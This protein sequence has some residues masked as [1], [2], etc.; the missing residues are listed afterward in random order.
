MSDAD[1]ISSVIRERQLA[2]RRELDRRNIALKALQYDS[3]IPYQ[4]ILSYF[5]G[6]KDRQPAIMPLSAFFRLIPVL[7]R[8]LVDL[9]LPHGHMIIPVPEGVDHD[10]LAAKAGEFAL[11][12]AHARHPNSEAGIDIG[13]CERTDLNNKAAG[14]RAVP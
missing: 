4:T 6:E 2:V 12:Y 10:D 5:P 8:D 14:L 13:P 1:N 7:P 11:T 3:G 9:L